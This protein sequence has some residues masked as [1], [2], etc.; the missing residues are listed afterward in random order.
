M[1][2]ASKIIGLLA[3][4]LLIGVLGFCTIWTIRNWNVVYSSIDGSSIYTY[5]DIEKARNEAY[6]E[7]TKNENEYK[8]MLAELRNEILLLQNENSLL[9]KDNEVYKNFIQDFRKE[10]V[11][12]L[13]FEV[14]GV[15]LDLVPV[16]NG[17]TLQNVLTIISVPEKESY[18]FKGWSL[19]G[20]TII[21]SSVYKVTENVVLKAVYELKPY[22]IKFV[23]GSTEQDIVFYE[24]TAKHGQIIDNNVLTLAKSAALEYLLSVE[25]INCIDLDWGTEGYKGGSIYDENGKWIGVKSDAVIFEE[26][27]I[28]KDT[29]FYVWTIDK[30]SIDD[31]PEKDVD[32]GDYV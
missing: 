8:E 26:Y 29:I 28:T 1:K 25:G 16:D 2:S 5:E 4:I 22:T 18:D 6:A 20:Q 14:D 30:G 24:T 13:T 19:D 27:P 23:R 11:S 15:L 3:S 10:G 12:V 32:L 7:G 31:L 21:D 17:V 9:L